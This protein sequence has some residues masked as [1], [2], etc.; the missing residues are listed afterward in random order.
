MI[1]AFQ[2]LAHDHPKRVAGGNV[3]SAR[4]HELVAEGMLGTPVIV[5]QSA[6]FRSREMRRHVKGRVG[7]RSAEVP[8][9]RIVP[10]QHQGHAGHVPDVFQAFPAKRDVHGS[11]GDSKVSVCFKYTRLP[12]DQPV[13]GV[14]GLKSRASGPL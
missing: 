1:F 13:D 14:I 6:Q 5:T 10:E 9:L 8:G 7:Q 3:V 4:Q 11:T 2:R 12:A